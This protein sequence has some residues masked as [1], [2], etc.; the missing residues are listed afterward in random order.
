[1]DLSYKNKKLEKS[2]TDDSSLRKKYGDIAKKLK[3]RL[4]LLRTADSL[5][6]ISRLPPTRLHQYKGDREGEWSIDINTNWRIVFE[7]G[8]DNITKTVKGDTDKKIITAI[9]ILSIEDPH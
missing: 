4:I 6:D 7:I 8:Y 2:L 1:M 9:K 5:F 3:Q